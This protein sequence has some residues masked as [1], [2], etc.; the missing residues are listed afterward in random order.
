MRKFNVLIINNSV[1]EAEALGQMLGEDDFNIRIVQ[2][3]TSA[4]EKLKNDGADLVFIDAGLDLTDCFETCRALKFNPE[5]DEIPVVIIVENKDN[6]LI[7]ECFESGCDDYVIKPVNGQEL[8]KKAMMLIEL[9]FSRR[10]SKDI[11]HILEEK[12]AE[13]TVELEE[14]LLKL[15]KANKELE[16]LDI[17]KSEFLNLI[18]HEIRTP[19]NGI[20]GSLALIGRYHFTDEVNTYFSL[21]DASVKRLETFSNTILDASNLRLKGKNNLTYSNFSPVTVLKEAIDLCS[22]QYSAKGIEIALKTGSDK[23][24]VHADIRYLR[25]CL[26]AVIDNAFKFS[27]PG[28]TITIALN[29]TQ[30]GFLDITISDQGQGFSK[31]SLENIYQPL[32]NIHL[33]YDKNTGMGLHLA[34][35]I[36]EAHSGMISAGNIEPHGAEIK[37]EL[38]S[39]SKQ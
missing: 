1:E 15:N 38:P 33:H 32:S 13:R 35:L 27:P 21:L 17:A 22:A 25:K 19:L 34:K 4:L 28:G 3:G 29:S 11:N 23:A 8:I 7:N 31:D 30:K 12:I 37:I 2:S 36:V 9:K 10:M 24:L 26:L 5:Y 39:G 20:L 14:S 6:Q 16:S 18:S